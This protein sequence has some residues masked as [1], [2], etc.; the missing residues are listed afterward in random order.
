MPFHCE[1][2]EIILDPVGDETSPRT[3]YCLVIDGQR[4]PLYFSGEEAQEALAAAMVR[5]LKDEA[6]PSGVAKA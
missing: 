5:G 2:E 4:S 3:A 1:V 6:K